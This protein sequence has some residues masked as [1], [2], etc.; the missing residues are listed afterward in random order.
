[1]DL[2]LISADEEKEW[3]RIIGM[4]N[5]IVHNYLNLDEKVIKSIINNMYLKIQDFSLN[6]NTKSR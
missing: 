6:I 5:T 3:Q 2:Q 1:M 4:R